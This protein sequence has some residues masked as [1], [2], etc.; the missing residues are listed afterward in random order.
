MNSTALLIQ[1]KSTSQESPVVHQRSQKQIWFLF[2]LFVIAFALY[3]LMIR[4]APVLGGQIAPFMFAWG[5]CFLLYFLACFWIMRSKPLTGQGYWLEL[6]IIFLGA[7]VFRC[8]LLPLPLGLSRDAWRYLWDGRVIAHGFNPYLYTP[9]DKAL[10][11]LRNSVFHQ[12]P[13][14]DTIATYPPLAEVFFFIGYLLTPT[15]LFA[16]KALFVLCDLITCASLAILLIMKKMDPRR[17]LIYAWCP[18]PIVEFAVEGHLD[19]IAI[20]FTVLAVLCALSSWRGARIYAGIFLGL[21]TLAKL[22]PILLLLALVRRR[23][24]RLLSA[25]FLTI[26]IGYLPFMLTAHGDYLAP[27]Q[28]FIGQQNL[29]I[30]APL[31]VTRMAGETK[32][33]SA[34]ANKHIYTVIEYSIA[35]IA[36]LSVSFQRFRKCISVEAASLILITL[37]ITLYSHLFPWYGCAL[38]PWIAMLIEPLWM[39]HGLNTKSLAV[40]M[41]WYLSVAAILSYINALKAYATS[42]YWLL[43]YG[44]SFGV[45]LFGLGVAVIVS[46]VRMLQTTWR[47]TTIDSQP[48]A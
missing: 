24:W 39:K 26:F 29:L 33:L 1:D 16:T 8:M 27:I 21:A 23:D 37:A 19:A 22:Y 48:A 32:H 30:S 3:L 6:G 47:R 2:T 43:Y 45:M 14:R 20:V 7:V 15:Q 18:L 10:I 44:Y 36:L 12:T 28:A 40:A 17:V 4:V 25:C 13:W 34:V 46:L 5:G 9:F 41:C 38:L 35:G 31:D 11:P 42:H